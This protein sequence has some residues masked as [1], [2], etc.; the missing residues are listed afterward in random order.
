MGRKHL[1]S[2]SAEKASIIL[3]NK[4][5]WFSLFVTCDFSEEKS[6]LNPGLDHSNKTD[7]HWLCTC[8]TVRIQRICLT[9]RAAL[10]ETMRLLLEFTEHSST[11]Q[12]LRFHFALAIFGVLPRRHWQMDVVKYTT[13]V[14]LWPRAYQ[15]PDSHSGKDPSS[16]E[17]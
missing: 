9:F 6:M 14:V 12:W 3:S 4:A 16:R 17:K 2:S 8:Y 7:S 13:W 10:T 5:Q 1:S 11:S 15:C